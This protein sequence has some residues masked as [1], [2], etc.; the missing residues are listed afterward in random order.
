LSPEG[1]LFFTALWLLIVGG[2]LEA[3]EIIDW[4]IRKVKAKRVNNR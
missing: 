1:I 3:P 4:I 2:A